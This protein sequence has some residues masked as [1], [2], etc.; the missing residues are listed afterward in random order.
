MSYNGAPSC[1]LAGALLRFAFFS[2]SSS[3]LADP[4]VTDPYPTNKRSQK[5]QRSQKKVKKRQP[6]FG[7]LAHHRSRLTSHDDSEEGCN[8]QWYCRGKRHVRQWRWRLWRGLAMDEDGG[9]TSPAT[10]MATMILATQIISQSHNRYAMRP[11]SAHPEVSRSR[12][13][14]QPS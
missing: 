14:P 11:R 4:Q 8:L 12:L 6:S 10:T 9:A 5:R 13:S 1:A 3:E 2:L 7:R